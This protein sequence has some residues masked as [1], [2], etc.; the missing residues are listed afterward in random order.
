[1]H[2]A[3]HIVT[4]LRMLIRYC[5]RHLF[6]DIHA[7]IF[8]WLFLNILFIHSDSIKTPITIYMYEDKFERKLEENCDYRDS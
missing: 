2:V 7:V 4:L 6:L 8:S 3:F 5:T 1:M